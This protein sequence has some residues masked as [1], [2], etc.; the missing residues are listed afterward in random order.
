MNWLDAKIKKAMFRDSEHRFIFSYVIHLHR[1]DF[2]SFGSL[3]PPS[4]PA[5]Q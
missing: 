5:P 3:R 1:R 2:S 4:W